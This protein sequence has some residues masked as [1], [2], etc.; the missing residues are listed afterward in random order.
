[1]A[2]EDDGSA[3]VEFV[4]VGTFLVVL[5]LGIFQLGLVLYVRNVVVASAAEGA[6]LA[7]NADRTCEDGV[8]R[9][10]ELL[11]G[12]LSSRVRVTRAECG[13]D[14]AGGVRLVRVDVR[15]ELPLLLLPG[16]PA[17]V[18]VEAT[19]RAFDEEAQ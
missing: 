16:L 4:L 11:A 5:F 10:S 18:P 12:T 1:V 14:Q 9:T 7:A 2:A 15:V 17:A 13:P 3:V 6:R 19:G 8:A